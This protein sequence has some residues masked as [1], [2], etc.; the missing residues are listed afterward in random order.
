MFEAKNT[1]ELDAAAMNQTA[2]YL[3]DRIGRL[4]VIVTRVG[5]SEAIQRKAISVWNDSG[6]ARK[7][8]LVLSDEDML[9]LLKLTCLGG[10]SAKWMQQRYRR[11]RMSLQ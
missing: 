10:S 11:F 9:A 5:P 6:G 1:G 7:A 3:G 2:T 8:I 4:G